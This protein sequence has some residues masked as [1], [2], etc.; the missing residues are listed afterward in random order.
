MT[1][2]DAIETVLNDATDPMHYTDIA[3]EIA[4]RKLRGDQLGATPANTVATVIVV[5]MRDEANDSPFVRVE[6]G[7]YGLVKR[8]SVRALRQLLLRSP[9]RQARRSRLK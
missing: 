9:R 3:E 4:T 8:L 5:S 6:R 7:V 2:R 1:W